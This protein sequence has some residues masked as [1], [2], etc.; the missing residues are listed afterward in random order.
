MN[1]SHLK[2]YTSAI[3][4][5]LASRQDALQVE[6]AVTFAVIFESEL[7]KRLA[8]ETMCQIFSSVGYQARQPTDRDW[9]SINRRISAGVALFDFL[10]DETLRGVAG[11]SVKGALIDAFVA[12]LK[13]YKLASVHDVLQVC[14]KVRDARRSPTPAP[15]THRIETAHIK[16]S[17]PARASRAEILEIA[18][19]LMQ[20][21]DEM[22]KHE[23]PA[24]LALVA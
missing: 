6:I 4:T 3:N 16:M 1:R 22:G 20:L 8:R 13:P 19:K 24:P 9:K 12:H 18:L 10:T 5:A 2:A 23:P 15:G 11:S 14:D 17:I 7:N 21:A